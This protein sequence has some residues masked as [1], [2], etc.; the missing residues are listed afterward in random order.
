MKV[1]ERED[2]SSKPLAA[3]IITIRQG[4]SY[5]QLFTRV[6]QESPLGRISVWL[7]PTFSLL[8]GLVK[9]LA[10]KEPSSELIVREIKSLPP[11]AV[12]FNFECCPGCNDARFP[13][14]EPGTFQL[15]RQLLGCGFFCMFSD[16]SLKALI[17]EWGEAK[18]EEPEAEEPA[19]HATGSIRFG[20]CPLVAT[21]TLSKSLELGFDPKQ[22]EACQSAQL[23]QVG[24]LCDHGRVVCKA[25]G[26]TIVYTLDQAVLSRSQE[27]GLYRCELLTVV[28]KADGVEPRTSGRPVSLG[29]HSGSAG[30]VL[31]HF[32]S[33]AAMLCSA[34]HWSQLVEVDV[35]IDKLMKVVAEQIG[36][37][38]V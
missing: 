4:G 34:G 37:A 8:V 9:A 21:G 24:A 36:R 28:T 3:A 22:L 35:S 32:P 30:H 20:P 17:T 2:D 5:D 33:G 11:S 6:K 26:G 27:Q 7:A 16:F 29:S 38:H 31:F 10:D 23:Q 15:T 14:T 25:A 18:E 12:V 19:S 13:K 1:H